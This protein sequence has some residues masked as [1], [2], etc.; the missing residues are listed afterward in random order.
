MRWGVVALK[1]MGA[2]GLVVAIIAVHL[3][4]SYHGVLQQFLHLLLPSIL[5]I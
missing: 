3:T 5:T 2:F 4:G 1:I